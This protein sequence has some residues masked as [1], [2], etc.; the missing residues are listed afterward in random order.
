M[1]RCLQV[2]AAARPE[3]PAVEK[4]LRGVYE[5]L[6]G[7][8]YEQV[9]RKPGCPADHRPGGIAACLGQA[10][11][12]CEAQDGGEIMWRRSG[13]FANVF[14]CLPDVASCGG[15]PLARETWP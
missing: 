1:I 10:A 6:A 4:T 11:N 3:I 7:K 14:W 8:P 5:R 2:D 9:R 12:R 13:N 15:L